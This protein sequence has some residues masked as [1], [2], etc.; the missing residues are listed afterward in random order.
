MQ[1]HTLSMAFSIILY[2]RYKEG[3]WNQIEISH[4]K[5]TDTKSQVRLI[6]LL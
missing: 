3:N 4:I 2:F 1:L 5:E 6:C